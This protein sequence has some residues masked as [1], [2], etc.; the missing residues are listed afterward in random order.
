MAQAQIV[1]TKVDGEDEVHTDKL[2]YRVTLSNL[3]GVEPLTVWLHK[4]ASISD[5]NQ[6]VNRQLKLSDDTVVALIKP[7]DLETVPPAFA[8]RVGSTDTIDFGNNVFTIASDTRFIQYG[9]DLLDEA[10]VYDDDMKAEQTE[11]EIR[12]DGNLKVQLK[13]ES[14]LN[15]GNAQIQ[16]QRTLRIP[17]DNKS[18]PLPPSLGHFPC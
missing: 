7:T 16:F 14:T 8:V 17:D 5:M 4:D 3:K 11:G 1:E 10:K 18:Y 6:M 13:D 2:K 15:I 9:N 12:F